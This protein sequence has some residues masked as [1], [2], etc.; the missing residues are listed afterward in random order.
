M[1]NCLPEMRGTIETCAASVSCGF[2]A[3]IRRDPANRLTRATIEMRQRLIN[4]R[5]R[6][7]L[8]EL[9]GVDE[10]A[11]PEVRWVLDDSPEV[12]FLRRSPRH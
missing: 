8:A 6:A 11:R 1:A 2:E 7:S 5:S 9:P 12:A 3:L 10:T 4:R